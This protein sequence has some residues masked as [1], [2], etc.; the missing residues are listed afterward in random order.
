VAISWH[1]RGDNSSQL[2]DR[3]WQTALQLSAM[4]WKWASGSIENSCLSSNNNWN[5]KDAG[6]VKKIQMLTELSY[7]KKEK[8]I[9]ACFAISLD[10]MQFFPYHDSRFRQLV[11][12]LLMSCVCNGST[13]DCKTD[14]PTNLGGKSS[15]ANKVA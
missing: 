5:S 10:F 4:Q 9:L 1:L 3:M 15:I 12:P 8:D 7:N 11:Y 6:M 13:S 14:C 2:G